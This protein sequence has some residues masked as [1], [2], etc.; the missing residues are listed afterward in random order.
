MVVVVEEG[1][2]GEGKGRAR[3]SGGK[4]EAGATQKGEERASTRERSIQSTDPRD[5]GSKR[6]KKRIVSRAC[7]SRG[8]GV[9]AC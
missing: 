8:V 1:R 4:R 6:K 7:V 9:G 2:G 3:G 5:G